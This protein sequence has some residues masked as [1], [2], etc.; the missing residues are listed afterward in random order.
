MIVCCLSIQVYRMSFTEQV[1]LTAVAVSRQLLFIVD[2]GI[3]TIGDLSTYKYD[4]DYVNPES[5][6]FISLQ[7]ELQIEV[8][9]FFLNTRCLLLSAFYSL[10]TARPPHVGKQ[11]LS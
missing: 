1:G 7:D 11:P 9:E 10:F 4:P 5:E 8:S 2:F 6:K 3:W